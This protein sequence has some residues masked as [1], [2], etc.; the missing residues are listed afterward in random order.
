MAVLLCRGQYESRNYR[1]CT[2]CGYEANY[3]LTD[4][5]REHPRPGNDLR[6][7]AHCPQCGSPTRRPRWWQRLLSCLNVS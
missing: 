2:D 4:F 7:W 3:D 6:D 1:R 5:H